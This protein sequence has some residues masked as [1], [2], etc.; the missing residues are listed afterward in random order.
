MVTKVVYNSCFGGFS[1][2]ERALQELRKL[3]LDLNRHGWVVDDDSEDAY[4][5]RH[6]PRLVQVVESLGEGANGSCADL[7]VETLRGNRYIVREYDG[8][9]SVIEPND[10][11]WIVAKEGESDE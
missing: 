4:V 5:P 1:L 2:S 11:R 6:D 8:S 10:I 3:G 9:E 7:C